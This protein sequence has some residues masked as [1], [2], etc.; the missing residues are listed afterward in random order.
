MEYL[1]DIVN[2]LERFSKDLIHKYN[3]YSDQFYNYEYF[4]DSTNNQDF[5]LCFIN[6]AQI[7]RNLLNISN[8]GKYKLTYIN[9]KLI[10][11]FDPELI[12]E[13][14]VKYVSISSL[15]SESYPFS[16]Y[17]KF[18]ENSYN[19]YLFNIMER[20]S[21]TYNNIIVDF[22]YNFSYSPI[23]KG[24]Y[25]NNKFITYNFL[26]SRTIDFWI[27]N[28]TKYSNY[29]SKILYNMDYSIK[30]KD[31]IKG[32]YELFDIYGIKYD[33]DLLLE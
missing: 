24:I 16:I 29:E 14:K 7:L 30:D 18:L 32:I 13:I 10:K 22:R 11:K 17:I 8:I 2:N 20:K 19:I 3:N 28:M 21:I 33:D 12:L 9:Q 15:E 6:L 25:K 4:V 27:F 26:D 31:I 5:R 23:F 1:L